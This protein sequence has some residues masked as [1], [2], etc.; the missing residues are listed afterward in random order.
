MNHK[1]YRLKLSDVTDSGAIE[2]HGSIANNID[3]GGDVVKSGAFQRTL[4]ASKGALP[5]LFNHDPA[6][7]IGVW[8][9]MRED[10]KGLFV[11]GRLNM[12]VA[13]AREIHALLKQGAI[14]GLS[15]GYSIV[16]D[17]V[18]KG[19][20]HL[21][22]LKLYEVSIVVFP[23][24]ELAS[25]ESVKALESNKYMAPFADMLD[26]NTVNAAIS[27]AFRTLD[28]ALFMAAWTQESDDA[29]ATAYVDEALS[30]FHAAVLDLF[31]KRRALSQAEMGAAE[32]SLAMQDERIVSLKSR[33]HLALKALL[34][35]EA[36]SKD[37][38][39]AHSIDA[40]AESGP[41]DKPQDSGDAAH[42]DGDED[43]TALIDAIRTATPSP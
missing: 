24:N 10:G 21:L 43:L 25:V 17:K 14:K 1:F 6:E 12:E 32:K 20:R 37:S 39:A 22:E 19:V 31:T 18:E 36:V 27:T 28:D 16:K 13:R 29:E 33:V 40:E 23:M 7:P 42:S 5:I 9:E 35:D 41:A 26:R 30:Q 38:G 3:L 34:E 8:E 4:A 11:K 15:I 2:G